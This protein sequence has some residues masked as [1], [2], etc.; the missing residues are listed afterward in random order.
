MDLRRPSL[1]CARPDQWIDQLIDKPALCPQVQ[2]AD[3]ADGSCI[4]FGAWPC[5]WDVDFKLAAPK[6]T[7]VEGVLRSGKVLE[8]VVTPASRAQFVHVLPCQEVE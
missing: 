5:S 4:V 8:L 6:G 1:A 7:T 2:P 3:D